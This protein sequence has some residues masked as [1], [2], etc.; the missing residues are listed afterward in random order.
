MWEPGPPA[1]LEAEAGARLIVNASG[2]PYLRGKGAERERMF[3]ERAARLRRRRSRSA[4]WSAARTSSSSTATASSSTPTGAVVARAQQFEPD[5]L[6][7]ELGGDGPARLEEPL[8]RPRRGLRRA[9]ARGPR[10]HPQERLRAGRG[11]ALGRHRLG[12]G[13][14]DRRRRARP[15][16]AHLRGHALP[17]LQRGDPGRRA[18]DRR[19]PRRRADRAR[20]S[21]RRWRAYDSILAEQLVAARAWRP[22]TSRRGSA[23]TC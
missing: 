15:G 16:A 14:A 6:L 7:W 13:R 21:R 5:L 23:A 18:G 20:R 3:A 2:S 4:T 22:R 1:S 19:Q 8:A 17:A 11:R 12:P 9:R 10:L